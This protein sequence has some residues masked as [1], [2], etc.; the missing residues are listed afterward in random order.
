MISNYEGI[1]QE[2]P[3]L[4]SSPICF[5]ILMRIPSGPVG[6]MLCFLSFMISVGF[7]N[8]CERCWDTKITSRY[9]A[10]DSISLQNNVC[11]E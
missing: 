7:L 4:K 11:N 10:G 6:L 5:Y 8:L 1:Y 3:K 9:Q 2:L